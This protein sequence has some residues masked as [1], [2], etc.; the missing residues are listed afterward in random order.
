MRKLAVVALLALGSLLP[1]VSTSADGLE[2]RAPT[3]AH[4]SAEMRKPRTDAVGDLTVHVPFGWHV[5]RQRVSGVQDPYPRLAMATFAVRLSP[6]PCACDTPNIENLPRRG[7]FLLVWEYVH[8]DKGHLNKIPPRP[9]RFTVTQ[10][11]P[12]WFECAGP[13]WTTDFRTAERD[14]QVEVHLGREAGKRVRASVEAILDT[15]VVARAPGA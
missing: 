12:R 8:I 14:F 13:S 2:P 9:P 11:N 7:A 4:T 1:A 10:D 3:T 5:V 6:H 15:L